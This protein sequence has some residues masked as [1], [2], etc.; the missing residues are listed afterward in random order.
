[1]TPDHLTPQPSS[2]VL[3][4]RLLA[5]ATTNAR[6]EQTQT[7]YASSLITKSSWLSTLPRFTPAADTDAC[8]ARKH[9]MGRS[10]PPSSYGP[11]TMLGGERF[12]NG[13]WLG[14]IPDAPWTTKRKKT[15]E[16]ALRM[17]S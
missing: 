4:P 5:Q 6:P 3:R 7:C 17:N 11:D 1:M 9:E 15:S 10:T 2:L 14:Q 13:Q 8:C 12:E 16:A